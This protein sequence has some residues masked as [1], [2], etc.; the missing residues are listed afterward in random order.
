MQKNVLGRLK[1]PWA[2]WASAA[3]NDLGQPRQ[4]DISKCPWATQ[5]VGHF[6]RPGTAQA[7]QALH[8]TDTL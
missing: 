2:T 7:K 5:A 8:A 6:G 1:S 3:A 4:F